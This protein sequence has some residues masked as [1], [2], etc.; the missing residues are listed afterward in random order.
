MLGA[1]SIPVT[2][3]NYESELRKNIVILSA[4][5]RR[6]KIEKEIAGLLAGTGSSESADLV[7]TLIYLRNIRRRFRANSIQRIWNCLRKF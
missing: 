4:D 2:I 5:E 7:E 3:A 1:C 6:H